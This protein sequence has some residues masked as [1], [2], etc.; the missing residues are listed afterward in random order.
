[1][2]RVGKIV[3]AN[4]TRIAMFAFL[5]V[6]LLLPTAVTAMSAEQRLIFDYGI[7][8]YDVPQGYGEE[9]YPII[10]PCMGSVT[11]VTGS[12]N[13]EKIWNYFVEI[14]IVGVSDN[15]AVIAGI[16]GN[17]QSE[18][19]LNPFTRNEFG[20]SGLYQTKD[21]AFLDV[22]TSAGFDSYWGQSSVPQDIVDQAILIQLDHLTQRT[23]RFS[24]TAGW[25]S[26]ISF[27]QHLDN[28][29]DKNSARSYAE[30]FL[31]SVEGGYPG[32]TYSLSDSRVKSM[33]V[34]MGWTDD[35]WQMTGNGDRRVNA[36][37]FLNDYGSAIGS[38]APCASGVY[39]DIGAQSVLDQFNIDMD[40]SSGSA[41]A[42]NGRTYLVGSNGCTTA[43]AW[44]IT[45]YTTL[46]YG[47]GDGQDVVQNLIDANP[48]IGLRVTDTPV[49]PAIFSVDQYANAWWHSDTSNPGHTGVVLAVSGNQATVLHTGSSRGN[50][51]NW[52]DGKGVKWRFN[53][54][55]SAFTFPMPGVKFVNIGEYVKPEL[56]NE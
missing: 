3:L 2:L 18:S 47:G 34:S 43:S 26:R 36:E 10:D 27:M 40:A 21:Q 52:G 35:K 16:M 54:D 25:E 4:I 11:T 12:T 45:N 29:D 49:P 44:F 14:G 41:T 28:V 42:N 8:D 37:K 53:S 55:G 6:V 17:L 13:A 22:M 32:G 31:V 20:Y 48:G 19:S 7:S 46:N 24:A 33:A 15:A 9:D 1:M 56:K 38:G 51:A 39:V 23:P 30:L 50:S 5:I